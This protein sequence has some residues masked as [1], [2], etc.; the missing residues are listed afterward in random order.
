MKSHNQ[1]EFILSLFSDLFIVILR[2]ECSIA[3]IPAV[4]RNE[5]IAA[6]E[7]AHIDDTRF[8]EFIADRIIATKLDLLRLLTDS[9]GVKSSPAVENGGVNALEQQIM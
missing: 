3:L 6:L 9:G 1:K 4:L 7:L 5:Y 2:N 8:R